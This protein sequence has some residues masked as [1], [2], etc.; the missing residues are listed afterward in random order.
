MTFSSRCG[1][2][3]QKKRKEGREGRRE[4]GKKEGIREK[5]GREGVERKVRIIQW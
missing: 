1:F 4:G 3:L 2:L 5:G